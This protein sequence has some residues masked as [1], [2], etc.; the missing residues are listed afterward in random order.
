[1]E[2]RLIRDLKTIYL[3]KTLSRTKRKD[4]ENYVINAVWQ[5]LGDVFIEPV[6]QQYVYNP[7]KSREINGKKYAHYF[8]DLYFPGLNIGIECDEAHH[9]NEENQKADAIRE[10]N[11]YDALHEIEL[12]S[13]YENIRIDVTQPFDSIQNQIDNA[14]RRI[15]EKADKLRS[16]GKLHKWTIQPPE[17]YLAGKTEITV[18]D[19]IGFDTIADT[20]NMLF[21]AEYEGYQRSVAVPKSF[22]GKPEFDNHV[23]WFPKLRV[24][25]DG[26]PVAATQSGWENDLVDSG[27]TIIARNDTKETGDILK[28]NHITF[29]W[30]KDALGITSYKFV[31]IFEPPKAVNDDGTYHY[32]RIKDKCPLIK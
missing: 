11:I 13:E 4:Y 1:M 29:A 14:V 28:K 17:E 23:L 32:K 21:S 22:I 16:E 12:N 20:C 8:I 9:F 10:A 3:I 7:I 15:K 25:V 30:Q 19:K 5:R 18:R 26:E 24:F 27:L 6:S 31:G 2:Q